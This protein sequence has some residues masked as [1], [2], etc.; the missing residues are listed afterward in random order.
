MESRFSEVRIL[1]EASIRPNLEE[2]WD[3]VGL[4]ALSNLLLV[5]LN[6]LRSLLNTI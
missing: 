6:E 4:I 1:Q 5:T 3:K 2:K